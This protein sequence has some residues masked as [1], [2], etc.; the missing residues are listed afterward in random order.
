MIWTRHILDSAQLMPIIAEAR[1]IADLG[2]GAGLPGLVMAILMADRAGALVH[3]VESNG[4]KAAFLR[5]AVRITAA[6]AIVHTMRVE[7]FMLRHHDRVDVVTARAL[8]SLANL[9]EMSEPLLKRGTRGVFPKGRAA[10]EELTKAARYWRI[11]AD[12][13][14]SV[15]DSAAHIIHVRRAER[16]SPGG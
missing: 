2:T 15:T 14:P 11:T 10:A 1:I 5:D 13:I 3:L 6:P 12:L 7:A 16:V 8:A 4:R 9:L